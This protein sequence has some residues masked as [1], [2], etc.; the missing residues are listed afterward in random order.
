[1]YMIC[2]L[3]L[4]QVTPVLTS[5]DL[6]QA[7]AVGDSLTITGTASVTVSS[8]KCSV[9]QYLCAVLAEGSGASYVDT[10]A[11]P[12]D[13]NYCIDVT[14]GIFAKTCIPGE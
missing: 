1:M 3:S 4:L 10:N 11:V 5:S 13:N 6:Q 12:F 2:L 8:L 7:L 9:T 14:T